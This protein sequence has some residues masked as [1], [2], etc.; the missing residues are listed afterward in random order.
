M[1][2]CTFYARVDPC[3]RVMTHIVADIHDE[4]DW[5]IAPL[6]LTCDTSHLV[7]EMVLAG[8]CAYLTLGPPVIPAVD[9]PPTVIFRPPFVKVSPA[10]YVKACVTRLRKVR[11]QAHAG[12]RA[13]QRPAHSPVAINEAIG[14][15]GP[16]G[17]IYWRGGGGDGGG[18]RRDGGGGDG[19][20]GSGG[21]ASGM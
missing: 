8:G 12:S 11:T 10:V 14:Q 2:A 17:Q 15:G 13:S 9:C 6:Q 21:G 5:R 19:R 4:L 18:G 7:G 16:G 3:V 1:H 20:G